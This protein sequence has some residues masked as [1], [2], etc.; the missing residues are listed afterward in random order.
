M[1][2]IPTKPWTATDRTGGPLDAVFDQLREQHPN[3]FVERMTVTPPTV[4][5]NVYIIGDEQGRDRVQVDT[6][7]G[8]QPP[9]L[10][11]GDVRPMDETSDTAEAVA[12]IIRHLAAPNASGQAESR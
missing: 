8:G 3:V 11:E 6:H 12:I 4:D 2:L 10:I 1:R 5:D 9:F 7:E